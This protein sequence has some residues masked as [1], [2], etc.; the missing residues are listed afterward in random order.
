MIYIAGAP[1]DGR[2]LAAG[3]A[4]SIRNGEAVGD[5]V[6]KVG[7]FMMRSGRSGLM[8]WEVMSQLTGIRRQLLPKMADR[9]AA[10][11]ILLN[12]D[13]CHR[14]QALCVAAHPRDNLIH[15]FEFVQYDETPLKATVV[16]DAVG[17]ASSV[18]DHLRRPMLSLEQRPGSASG[19]LCQIS[20]SGAL[21]VRQSKAPQKIIQ[22][23]SAV[24]MLIKMSH[25]LT[26]FVYRAP[27]R[28]CLVES[29]TAE[30]TKA[31]QLELSL[32]DRSARGFAGMSRVS[33][34]DA[35]ASNIAAAKI[36]F[37]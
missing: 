24:A 23:R 37:G 8:T 10:A 21:A 33:T 36:N 32:V 28:L 20:P 27:M 5:N 13:R 18:D 9:C 7:E 3:L 35:H 22:T 25:G 4:L 12:A 17:A 34:T 11:S 29:N 30:A 31:A 16:G 1:H 6:R 19:V 14:L 26:A 2:A 15:H